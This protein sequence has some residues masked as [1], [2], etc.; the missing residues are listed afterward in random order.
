MAITKRLSALRKNSSKEQPWEDDVLKNVYTER[1]AYAAEH[2]YDLDRLYADL[3]S[4]EAAS[5][6]RRIDAV[7]AG[8][9]DH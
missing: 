7:S 2:G 1:D 4:R 8:Q 9:N 3:K 6:L 5:F